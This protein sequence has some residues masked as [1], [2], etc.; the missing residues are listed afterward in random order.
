MRVVLVGT[1][2]VAKA[3]GLA[4]FGHKVRFA[5]VYGRNAE[6]AEDLARM[7]DT[8][9]A[10]NFSDLPRQADLY[11]LAVSDD[12]V[13]TVSMQLGKV[14]GLVVHVSGS[15]PLAVLAQTHQRSGVLY[16]LQTCSAERHVALSDVPI[17]IQA[18]Q[19]G[20][21]LLLR[22]IANALSSK[23][24][25]A[26]DDMRRQLHLA[27]VFACNFVNALYTM[28]ED[29]LV[30]KNIDFSLLHPLILE[31]AQKATSMSP[32]L[33]QTGPAMR[34]DMKAIANHFRLLEA[35]DKEKT[36]YHQITSYLLDK[37]HST[38]P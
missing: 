35:F 38:K 15:L 8:T 12:A 25:E 32:A 34:A 20:D 11:L 37:Y 27:A 30:S 2:N 18:N 6:K 29:L 33:A 7:L 21:L 36:I 23:A 4:L 1:G 9:P 17:L 19:P 16:P 24:V 28:S 13:E 26:T 10:S 3:L 14:D 31:T 22:T 5:S